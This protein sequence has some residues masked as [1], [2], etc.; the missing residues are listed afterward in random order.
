MKLHAVKFGLAAGILW[1]A[2]V[3][4]GTLWLLIT[5]SGGHTWH[6]LSNFYLGF[7]FS[8]VGAFVGLLWGFADGF[9]G[10]WLLATLY[11]LLVR[12]GSAPAT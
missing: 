11:N 7:S 5:G 1:G 9:V 4:F 6:L 12:R 8:Y 10:G 3:F 2:A